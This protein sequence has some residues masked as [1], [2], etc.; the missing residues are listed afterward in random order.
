MKVKIMNTVIKIEPIE[1]KGRLEELGLKEELLNNSILKG[2]IAR[3]ESTLNHPP[4][5]AGFITWANIVKG[6][7]EELIPLG[8][9]RNDENMYSR[10]FNP[11]GTIAIAVATGDENTGNPHINSMTKSSKGNATNK[12]VTINAQLSLN[13][14]FENIEIEDSENNKIK[15]WLLMFSI[16]NNEVLSELSLPISFNGKVNG[17]NE[18]IILGSIPLDPTSTDIP[19]SP[20]P[21]LPDIDV[22]I[23][24]R[25]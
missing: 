8:W 23:S 21:Q 15:T 19:L 11:T 9:V 12:A 13:F 17:W 24:R 6:L 5:Y 16:N 1:V 10:I 4:L 18:R 7:R 3:S 14:G 22:L 25:A 2:L 20:L